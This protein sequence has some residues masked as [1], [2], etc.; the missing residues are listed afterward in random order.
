MQTFQQLGHQLMEIAGFLHQHWERLLVSL[1]VVQHRLA[2]EFYDHLEHGL[3][4][5]HFVG[6]M[7]EQVRPEFRGP[8]VQEHQELMERLVQLA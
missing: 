6:Q 8:Q 3:T 2:M 4:S 1:T 7:E 5:D